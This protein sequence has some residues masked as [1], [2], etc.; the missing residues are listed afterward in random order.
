[1]SVEPE[2]P[3]V[4]APQ[5]L[6]VLHC[7]ECGRAMSYVK[8]PHCVAAD[9]PPALIKFGELVKTPTITGEP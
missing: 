1:M 2:Q 5:P 9:L 8:C 4:P 6:K 3:Q 7:A